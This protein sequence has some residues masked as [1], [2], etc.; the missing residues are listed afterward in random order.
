[1]GIFFWYDF[2]T[3]KTHFTRALESNDELWYMS[4]ELI[5]NYLNPNSPLPMCPLK[6]DMY[7]LGIVCLQMLT[8]GKMS[9]QIEKSLKEYEGDVDRAV[10]RWVV[11]N[12]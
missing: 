3:E 4:P 6:C 8:L 10:K 12:R 7:S 5:H 11:N 2:Q 1:M 9:Q